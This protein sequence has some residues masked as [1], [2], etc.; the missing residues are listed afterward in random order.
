MKRNLLLVLVNLLVIG[1]FAQDEKEV[2]TGASYVDDVYYSLEDGLVSSAARNNWDLGFSTS[3]FSV[4][5]LANHSSGVEVYTYPSG[6]TADWASLDTTGMIW[7]QMYNSIETFDEGAFMA[8]ASSHPDYGWG[9]YNM[10]THNITGDSL[11][12]VKTVA[13]D[14]KK[15]AI[16]MRGSM[17]NTWDFKFANL[18]GTEEQMVMLNSGDYNTK[19]FVY[20]SIDNMTIVDREPVTENWDMLFTK[21]WDYT[22]PYFVTGVLTN[23]NHILAQEIQD[24]N[25]DQATFMDFED[26]TFT[27]DISILGSD[28]KSFNME[29]FAYDVDSTVVFFL[30]KMGE[31]DSSYYKLYFTGFDYT[32]GKYA[33][34]QELLSFVSTRKPG[35]IQMLQVYPNPASESLNVVFDHAGQTGIQ[36]LDITGRIVYSNLYETPGLTTLQLDINHL[37]PGLFF[38]KVNAGDNNGVLRFIKD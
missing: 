29:T 19:S 10:S 17:A 22:I 1:V 6:D 35:I 36:I 20:Y 32:A 15:L 12:V 21:Y 30:K 9:T 27:S 14:Y 3:N 37:N 8:N 24:D 18:D 5:I 38:L 31:T 25:L 13:G 28:W 26:T 23:E 7:K 34:T 11:F 4:S 16:I 33:F 2:V